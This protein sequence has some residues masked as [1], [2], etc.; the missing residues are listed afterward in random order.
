MQLQIICEIVVVDMGYFFPNSQQE[1]PSDL[2][3]SRDHDENMPTTTHTTKRLEQTT[4]S[5]LEQFGTLCCLRS[6]GEVWDLGNLSHSLFGDDDV[7]M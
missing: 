2:H 4:Q 7:M 6:F 3:T 5:L 1:V